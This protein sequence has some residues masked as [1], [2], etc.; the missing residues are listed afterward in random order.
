MSCTFTTE[1]KDD[2]II[3][4]REEMNSII[5]QFYESVIQTKEKAVHVA[6]SKL[7]WLAPEQANAL[8]AERDQLRNRLAFLESND[9]QE[10]DG[11]DA[12]HPA[13]WRGEKD[14][15]AG[16]VANLKA[17]LGKGKHG[18]SNG[19]LEDLRCKIDQLR[20]ERDALAAK[21]AELEAG[22]VKSDRLREELT[23]VVKEIASFGGGCKSLC[24]QCNHAC[25]GYIVGKASYALASQ[26]KAEG[27][28]N[29]P[30]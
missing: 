23:A 26:S 16:A 20:K 6:L 28:S 25:K 30:N 22:L 18:V 5:G 29:E 9:T 1:I 19:P 17:V 11:T 15:V 13:Y 4:I 10:A 14:G 24:P 3:K 12:A 2:G 27:A 21:V 7:G 8:T